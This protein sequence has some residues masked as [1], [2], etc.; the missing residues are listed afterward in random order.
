MVVEQKQDQDSTDRHQIPV[1]VLTGDGAIECPALVQ[2]PMPDQIVADMDAQIGIL[3][4]LEIEDLIFPFDQPFL[5]IANFAA[6][7]EQCRD[8]SAH[9]NSPDTS[10]SH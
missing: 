3:L 2:Q 9:I 5:G 10:M 6:I 4:L 7:A 8:K 1:A